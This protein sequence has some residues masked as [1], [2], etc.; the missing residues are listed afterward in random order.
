MILIRSYNNKDNLTSII[1][2][3]RTRRKCLQDLANSCMILQ[4]EP[5]QI[6]FEVSK[7]LFC[8]DLT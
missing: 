2:R 3:E 1:S 4:A 8:Q 6:K 5:D 7:I